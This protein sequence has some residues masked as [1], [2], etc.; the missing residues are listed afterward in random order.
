MSISGHRIQIKRHGR[1][2]I[3]ES[4]A[5]LPLLAEAT[6]IP[7]R[8]TRQKKRNNITNTRAQKRR[9]RSNV[10]PTPRWTTT[11]T[12]KQIDEHDYNPAAAIFFTPTPTKIPPRNTRERARSRGETGGGSGV[13]TVG[14]KRHGAPPSWRGLADDAAGLAGGGRGEKGEDDPWV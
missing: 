8:N 2:K 12:S 11:S 5:M 10:Y 6:E 9:S 14:E 13:H 3:D 4:S 1:S 7:P